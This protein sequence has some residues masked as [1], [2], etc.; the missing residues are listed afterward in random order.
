VSALVAPLVLGR[1][2]EAVR[3]GQRPPMTSNT[4]SDT[5]RQT[6]SEDEEEDYYEDDD[7]YDDEYE[8]ENDEELDVV[9]A[10]LTGIPMRKQERISEV[11]PHA[12]AIEDGNDQDDD[13]DNID[14]EEG[15]V[16]VPRLQAMAMPVPAPRASRLV[17]DHQEVRRATHKMHGIQT[18]Y[19]SRDSPF[20]LLFAQESIR[21]ADSHQ[22]N[23]R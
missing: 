5:P 22:S 14:E 10:S 13:E 4:Y 20:N 7:E 11:A 17:I 9:Y 18:I 12:K 21:Q 15:T 16:P 19:I 23:K 1:P 6:S 8:D 3:E 2:A